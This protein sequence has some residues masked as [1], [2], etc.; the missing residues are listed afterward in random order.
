MNFQTQKE[1]QADTGLVVVSMAKVY[2]IRTGKEKPAGIGYVARKRK[3]LE[4]SLEI[5]KP[6]DCKTC[7]DKIILAKQLL[8]ESRRLC[9]NYCQQT[10]NTLYSGDWFEIVVT[11]ANSLQKTVYPKT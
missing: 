6:C 7:K 9:V 5:G 4:R 2:D 10:G 3:C 11:A 1:V 8:A